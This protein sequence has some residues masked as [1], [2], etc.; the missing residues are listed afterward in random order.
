[1]R[2]GDYLP[3]V[4]AGFL[5]SVF[6]ESLPRETRAT[7]DNCAMCSDESAA[8]PKDLKLRNFS[9]DIKCCTYHPSLPNFLVG[10]ILASGEPGLAEGRKRIREKIAKGVS[11]TPRAVAAPRKY[12]LL[13]ENVHEFFG[14]AKAMACPYYDG[15]NCTIWLHREAVCTTYFCKH[16][17]GERGK[18]FWN[19]LKQ[20]LATVELKLSLYCA[21]QLVS[22]P[23]RL[24]KIWDIELKGPLTV[25]DLEETAPPESQRAELWG[26]W[27]G[28]EEAFY[29]RCHEL[30][31][32]LTPEKFAGLAGIEETFLLH[33]LTTAFAKAA[34]DGLPP[35][36]KRNPELCVVKSGGNYLVTSQGA[37]GE[38]FELSSLFYPLLEKFDGTEEN[39]AV[40]K[41]LAEN[42]KVV[43]DTQTL[44]TLY[45]VGILM[46]AL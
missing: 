34:D 46:E 16:V 29:I 32:A 10:G 37:R 21:S 23:A 19:E 11:V 30:V 36:L 13:Y 43:I 44:A 7:C 17:R 22:D 45:N 20:Y 12:S 4:Y 31:G 6:A 2:L 26:E 18:A 14:R 28:R 41:Q 42:D 24:G 1:M 15:G 40:L 33:K 38:A 9:P 3:K 39:G 8:Q 27:L 35:K 5:P 25:Q